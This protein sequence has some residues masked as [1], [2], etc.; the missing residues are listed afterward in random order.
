MLTLRALDPLFGPL[1]DD[2]VS[3]LALILNSI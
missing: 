3:F 2:S 1:K